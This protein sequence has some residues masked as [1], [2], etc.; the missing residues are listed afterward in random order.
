MSRL[1]LMVRGGHIRALYS[2][3]LLPTLRRLGTPVVTRASHVE[4]NDEG[5]W[6]ADMAPVDGPVLGSFATR[7]EALSAEVAWLHEHRGL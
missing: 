6:S 5:G 3:A 4:P 2:D 7:G 1:R